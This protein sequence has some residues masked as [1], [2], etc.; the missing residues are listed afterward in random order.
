MD[1]GSK[2]SAVPIYDR[3][4]NTAK[5]VSKGYLSLIIPAKWYS[6]GRGLDGF[7]KSM[8]NDNHISQLVDFEDS[9]ECFE[10]VDIAGG[11]CYFLRSTNYEGPCSYRNKFGASPIKIN[12]NDYDTFIRHPE[13]RSI[14]AK[15]Q[16]NSTESLEA[17]V[18]SQKPFGLR[19]YAKPDG[20]GELV[21]RYGGGK[22]PIKR[23]RVTTNTEWIGKWKVISSYL[24][25]DHAGRPDKDGKKRIM[26][27]MEILKPD[28]V[29][30]ETYL[31]L[32]TFDS[33]FEAQAFMKYMKCEFTRFLISQIATTQHLSKAS[34]KFV[35][36]QDF[37]S[38]SP[39][40]WSAQISEIDESLFKKYGLEKE[41]VDFIHSK[42]KPM[43]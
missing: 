37:T 42:I 21:L 22:G 6:G 35:P 23:E 18:S 19:T 33:E 5:I 29:C 7:R 1:G 14:I 10:G 3:I 9:K 31:V 20:S 11:V 13:A 32:G 4:T 34:F 16:K 25:Y 39:I 24:T 38:A 41:E 15:V 26:S 30:T 27:T 43:E 36:S 2:A 28:E 12:L 40:D 17:S 8:L